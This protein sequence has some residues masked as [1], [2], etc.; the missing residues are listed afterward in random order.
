MIG[1]KLPE[2]KI[3]GRDIRPLLTSQPEDAFAE[4]TYALYF[5]D[6]LQAVRRGKWKLHFPHR[7]RTLAGRDPGRD[8]MPVKYEFGDVGLELFDL[9][10]D[11][12]ETKNVADAHP[13]I[14]K[15]LQADG[16]RFREELGDALT[17][18]KGKELRPA[19]QL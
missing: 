3:D 11:P 16:Q 2:R 6:E 12:G 4:Q 7:Y 14:V 9:S 5:L 19:G 17:K 18:T 13:E 10:T 15:Q 8:G 1:A